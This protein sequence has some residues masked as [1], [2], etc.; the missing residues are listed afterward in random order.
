[1]VHVGTEWSQGMKDDDNGHID[2]AK[3]G[4]FLAWC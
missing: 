3:R 4:N 2:M 1:M